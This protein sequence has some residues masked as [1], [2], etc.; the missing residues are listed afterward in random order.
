MS[1]VLRPSSLAESDGGWQASQGTIPIVLSDQSDDTYAGPPTDG[2]AECNLL[3]DTG[4]SPAAGART[5][6]VRCF[7][8]GEALNLS[9]ALTVNLYQ[10]DDPGDPQGTA[11]LQQTWEIGPNI[12]SSIADHNLTVTAPI[13]DY[14]SL[15]VGLAASA[16]DNFPDLHVLDVYLT[17]P[18]AAAVASSIP[19]RAERADRC[20][21]ATR[22]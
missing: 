20:D 12:G 14:G 19:A 2:T 18:A 9:G 3:I 10:F 22:V 15:M 1:Q 17:I 13:T 21:R 7:D 8:A 11:V 5:L 4:S 6:T 16:W